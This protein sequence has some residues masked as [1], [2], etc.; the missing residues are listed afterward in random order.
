MNNLSDYNYQ[1]GAWTMKHPPPYVK[2]T[3]LLWSKVYV[4][5]FKINIPP[6]L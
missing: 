6:P 5:I 1:R 4:S 2:N 3:A